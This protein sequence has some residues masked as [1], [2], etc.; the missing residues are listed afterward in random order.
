MS[1]NLPSHYVQQYASNLELLLQQTNSRFSDKVMNSSHTG[2]QA[3][4][5]DQVA[6]VEMQT[7]AGRFAPIGRVDAAVD[8]RWVAPEDFD[9]PQLV[10]SFDKLRLLLDPTSTYVKNGVAAVNRRYD[11]SIVAAFFG[12]SL[13][14]KTGT[15]STTFLAANQVAVTMGAAAATGMNFKKL[16]EAKRILMSYDIDIEMEQIF[17]S[18]TAKQHDELLAENQIVSLDYADKAVLAEG[19]I[20]RVLGMNLVHTELNSLDS[21]S[22]RRCP[23][24]CKSGMDLGKWGAQV[25]DIAQRKDL[26]GLP[27][28]VYQA[29]TCGATRLDEKKVVEIK[30]SEA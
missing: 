14:G 29:M 28:Q 21:N 18:V 22:Y 10:D 13:T 5:V 15:T 6:A 8:R 25:T 4:L 16:R 23:V 17:F 9:L 19:K 26:S 20:V 3:A 27:Y 7:P 30:C 1:I 2:E 24:W 11:R 12:T